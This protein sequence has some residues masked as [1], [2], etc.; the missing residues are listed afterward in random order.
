MPIAVKD[1]S[2]DQN[3][4]M[5]YLTVP[6]KGVKTNKVDIFSSEEYLKVSY[7]PYIFECL[8][9]HPVDD[10]GSSAQLGNGAVIFKLK[11]T[12]SIEW[13]QL[14]SPDSVNKEIM[15][16]KRE[17][18]IEKVHKRAQEKEKGKSE[19]KR[20]NEKFSINQM[21]EIE[22]SD[23]QRIADLKQSERNKATDDLERWKDEQ[24]KIAEQERLLKEKLQE[25]KIN[26]KI[27][28]E[29][30]KAAEKENA[31]KKENVF[32]SGVRQTGHITIKHTPRVFP[33]P[34]RES[35]TPLEDEW[36][37]KQ[38]ESRRVVEL[39][40]KDLSEEEKNPLWLRDKGNSFFASGDYQSAISVYSHAIRLNPNIPGLY[41]N[42]A[43]CHLKIR[44]FFKAVEDSSKALEL[45]TPAVPQ[46][47]A[48]RVKAH[49]RRGTSFCELEMYVEGLMDYEAALKID[50]NN[51]QLLQ[52]ADRIR[53]I[54]QT[55]SDYS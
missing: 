8:L 33:T 1:F 4:K 31:E 46:N 19:V 2:W 26:N 39:E 10:E 6:L 45:L 30:L 55:S 5:V 35:T 52:D 27:K 42:R 20:N 28:K 13:S 34:V 32:D 54:I 18:A 9:S 21:M 22:E 25:E 3:D 53:N 38:A 49:I 17:E 51:D 44:N 40:D 14:Q 36:L 29:K 11:K 23:R 41:S 15:K 50:K 7:P 16:Q 37:K 24:I 47:A 48:S 43:A 12:E